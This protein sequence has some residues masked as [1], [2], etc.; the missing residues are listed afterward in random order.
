MLG[1]YSLVLVMGTVPGLALAGRQIAWGEF[2]FK[3]AKN[4]E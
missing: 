4:N 2:E 1:V 3:L